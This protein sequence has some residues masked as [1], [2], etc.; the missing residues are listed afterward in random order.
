MQI[1]L[2]SEPING[3]RQEMLSVAIKGLIAHVTMRSMPK[4]ETLMQ[5]IRTVLSRTLDTAYHLEEAFELLNYPSAC[6]VPKDPSLN[7]IAGEYSS[8]SSVPR[9]IETLVA[10]VEF[11]LHFS[12]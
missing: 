6:H 1:R 5:N 10:L 3:F 4:S 2:N 12:G 8:Q 11:F 7:F 9:A